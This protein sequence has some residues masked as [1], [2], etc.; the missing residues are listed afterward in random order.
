MNSLRKTARAKIAAAADVTAT[1]GQAMCDARSDLEEAWADGHGVLSDPH[2]TRS[3]LMRARKR[4]D[5]AMA[6]LDAARWP[7]DAD[8]DAAD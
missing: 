2:I 5:E 3:R 4:I 1:I 8:Y 7:S 6:A